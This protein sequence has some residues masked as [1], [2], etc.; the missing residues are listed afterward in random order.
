MKGNNMKELNLNELEQASGGIVA[1]AIGASTL[2]LGRALIY[3]YK[4]WL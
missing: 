2:A 4:K 3:E 1:I